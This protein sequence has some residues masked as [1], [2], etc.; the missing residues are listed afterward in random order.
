[1]KGVSGAEPAL[2]RCVV[3]RL[4]RVLSVNCD[5]LPSRGRRDNCVGLLPSRRGTT[6]LP[7]MSLSGE[8]P[9]SLRSEGIGNEICRKL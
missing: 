8:L 1:M 7:T 4:D 2:N 9:L 6:D 3:S 5:V